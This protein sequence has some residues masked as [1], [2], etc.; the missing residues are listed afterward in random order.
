MAI[1]DD[2]LAA[3][4]KEEVDRRLCKDDNSSEAETTPAPIVEETSSKA[5][6]GKASSGAI[7][8]L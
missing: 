3:A 7:T 6:E 8:Y 5:I 2:A 1:F 4:V